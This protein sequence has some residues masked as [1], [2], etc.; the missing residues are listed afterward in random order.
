[1]TKRASRNTAVDLIMEADI[2]LAYNKFARVIGCEVHYVKIN[3][4]M[5]QYY[6]CKGEQ[7]GDESA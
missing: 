7:G 4:A 2:A 5:E 1:M 6:G 3:F